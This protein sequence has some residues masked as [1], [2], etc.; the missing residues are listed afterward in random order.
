MKLFWNPVLQTHLIHKRT[1]RFANFKFIINTIQSR[2][3]FNHT[4]HV[5]RLFK[6]V[7]S[8]YHYC[9][10][11]F[12][13][14]P[15]HELLSSKVC[16]GY[17]FTCWICIRN[18]LRSTFKLLEKWSSCPS[19]SFYDGTLNLTNAGFSLNH[20]IP[21]NKLWVNT[22]GLKA[23]QTLRM[24]LLKLFWGIKTKIVRQSYWKLLVSHFLHVLLTSWPWKN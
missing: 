14:Y 12:R 1:S 18:E 8:G 24:K 23:M 19:I 4:L 5:N 13:W 20:G 22:S 15:G 7:I 3:H 10:G 21:S 2:L 9:H 17:L 6:V 11:N 16:V